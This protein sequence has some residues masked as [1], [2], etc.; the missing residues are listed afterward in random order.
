MAPQLKST[1]PVATGAHGGFRVAILLCT[2]NGAR[3]LGEQLASLEG[4]DVANIDIHCSDD[5][6]GDATRDILKDWQSRWQ[7]GSFTIAEGPRRGFAE[8][9]RALALATPLEADYF[10]FCDQDD[11]W[12]SDKLSAA[13]GLLSAKADRPA[14]YLSRTRLVDESGIEIG[15]SPL[16]RRPPAFRNAVVQSIGG[17]NT[18][19]MNRAAFSLF[20]RSIAGRP[21]VSH[22]W[23]AYIVVSGAGGYVHYDAIPHIDYRQHGAN[24]VGGNRGFLSTASRF[25]FLIK[26]GFADWLNRNLAGLGDCTTFLTEDAQAVTAKLI[27]IQRASRPQALLALARSGIYRQTPLGNFAL[28][29]AVILGRF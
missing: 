5:G 9:F 3:F 10:A 6:S 15:M 29:L 13:I 25:R 7:R 26:G 2:F 18:M 21:F 4:Q 28:W 20:Q 16:F 22:D 19:V 1:E 24:V 11:V 8:N 17:A 12:H 14:L 27:E 23:W